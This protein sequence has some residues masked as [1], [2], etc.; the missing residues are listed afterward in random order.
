LFNGYRAGPLV[1]ALQHEGD[2]ALGMDVADEDAALL[3]GHG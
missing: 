2:R 3:V 1:V